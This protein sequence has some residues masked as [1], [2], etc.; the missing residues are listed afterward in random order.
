MTYYLLKSNQI[1]CAKSNEKVTDK[2]DP[3]YRNYS[4]SVL[5][6]SATVEFYAVSKYLS[7]S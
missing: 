3:E 5:D 7:I 6:A 1:A 2:T 4:G